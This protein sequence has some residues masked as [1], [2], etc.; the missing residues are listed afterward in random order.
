[1][2][3][4]GLLAISPQ[5]VTEVWCLS[6]ARTIS[7]R[8]RRNGLP[9]LSKRSETRALPRSTAIENWNRSFEPTETKSTSCISSSSCHIS[10]G[11]SSIAPNCSFFGSAWLNFERCCTS[12]WRRSRAARISDTSVTIGSIMRNSAPEAAR[13]SA[14]ICVRIRPGRSSDRRIARQ[15][16][17]GFSSSWPRI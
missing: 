9:R 11:T 8:M 17:A 5:S 16:S 14:R 3:E 12:F 10:E 1:M 13:S 4:S 6:P 15:P 7:R 2:A